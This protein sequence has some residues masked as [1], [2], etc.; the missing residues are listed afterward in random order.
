MN[1]YGLPIAFAAALHSIVLF[2]FNCRTSKATVA[3]PNPTCGGCVLPLS[4]D[5]PELIV[6]T[7]YPAIP[8]SAEFAMPPLAIF[9]LICCL[10]LPPHEIVPTITPPNLEMVINE[11][12]ITDVAS[13]RG[14]LVPG[15]LIPSTLLDRVPATRVQASPAYPIEAAKSGLSG[16]VVIEFIVNELGDVVQARVVNST[17]RIF[18]E[19]ATRAVLNW[20]FEPGRRNGGVV[21]FRMVI[22]VHF[23][24]SD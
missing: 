14:V 13:P 5:E 10:Q 15:E 21:P 19:A 20:K 8:A 24:L 7:A 23:S 16:E 2:G 3:K 11:T 18:E 22:P 6:P 4:I 12:R 17:D 9:D 1:R